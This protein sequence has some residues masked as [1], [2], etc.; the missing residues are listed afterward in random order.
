MI[1][2]NQGELV[3][4]NFTRMEVGDNLIESLGM[5]LV[6]GRGFDMN[7]P[8][9]R[10]RAVIVNETAVAEMGWDNLIGKRYTFGS[11][12]NGLDG[13]VIGV[14]RDFHFANFHEPIRRLGI[15]LQ[16]NDFA[17]LDARNRELVNRHLV[18]KV[19]G[20]QT[21]QVLEQI[22]QSWQEFDPEHPFEYSFLNDSIDEQYQSE[23][24]QVELMNIF[25]LLAIAVSCLGVFGL[26]A[27]TTRQR[28]KEIGI[29]KVLGAS[30]C[31]IVRLLFERTLIIILISSMAAFV[32]SFYVINSWIGQFAYYAAINYLI[33][34]LSTMITLVVAF[35]AVGYQ[36]VKTASMNPVES[37]RHE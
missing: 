1:E 35:V 25:S 5:E 13:V 3:R 20:D 36:S 28:T 33:F 7:I 24:R 31:R 12:V 2:N 6:A 37:L 30:V 4:Q 32:I 16:G 18:V 29:R 27:L 19:N 14:V 21:S 9:D 8:N 23:A 11:G 15:H 10:N 34:P 22:N 17:A 26:T